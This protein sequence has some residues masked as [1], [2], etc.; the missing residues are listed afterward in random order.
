V[1]P[2]EVYRT[3]ILRLS[4]AAPLSSNCGLLRHFDEKGLSW[5]IPSRQR[6]TASLDG[7]PGLATQGAG[8]AHAGDSTRTWTACPRA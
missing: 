1:N 3:P 5:V 8:R 6:R 2:H 7:F 4:G